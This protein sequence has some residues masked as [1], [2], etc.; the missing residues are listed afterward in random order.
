MICGLIA[1]HLGHSFSGPIHEAIGDYPYELKELRPEEMEPFLRERDFQGI[2]VTI[3]YKQTVMPFLDEI[4]PEALAIDAV[5]T[6]VNRNGKLYGYNTD[7]GGMKALIARMGLELQDKKVLILGTGGT[8]KTALAVARSLKAREVRKVS[9]SGREGAI[10]YE[11][12]VKSHKDAQILINTTPCGMFPRADAQPVDLGAFHQLEGVVDAIYNPLSTELVLSAREKGIRAQGGLYMLVAQ[13]V[14]A[15][16]YFTGKDY[17][18]DLTDRIYT[19]LLKDKLNLVLI[20]MPSSGKS[21]LGLALEKLLDKAYLGLDKQIVIKDGRSIPEIFAENGEGF[22]RDLECEVTAEA[23]VLNSRIIA[24]GGGGILR[25]ENVRRLK[26][27]GVLVYL[28]RPLEQLLPTDDRPLA[29]ST[30]KIRRLYEIR[31]PLYQAAADIT[32]TEWS[33][34]EKTLAQILQ[35]WSNIR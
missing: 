26:R 2:N 35:E 16:G 21:T 24:T 1:E 6:I 12:A 32:I 28:D 34:I 8:S 13:A 33:S 25:Q 29:D 19:K 30:D 5:N 4:S 17:P 20:G 23:A 31:R 11:E 3:P 27:N 18:A 7:F 14:L 22:F 9:R 15:A 10:T